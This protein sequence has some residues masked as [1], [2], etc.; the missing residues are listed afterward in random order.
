MLAYVWLGFLGLEGGSKKLTVAGHEI[1]VRD[2]LEE[3]CIF[4]AA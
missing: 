2:R 1:A 4:K 3:L